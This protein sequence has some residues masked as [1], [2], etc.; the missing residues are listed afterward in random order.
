MKKCTGKWMEKGRKLGVMRQK[1]YI[2]S[3]LEN[4]QG[5]AFTPF[6]C[7]LPLNRV[8]PLGRFH[9]FDR[10]YDPSLFYL[11]ATIMPHLHPTSTTWTIGNM[12]S[13][14]GWSEGTTSGAETR[15]NLRALHTAKWQGT[16]HG[17]RVDRYGRFV[18]PTLP[19]VGRYKA[20]G[21]ARALRSSLYHPPLQGWDGCVK[22]RLVLGLLT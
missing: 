18:S 6:R 17:G 20:R 5:L 19:R 8:R 11:P 21:S 3:H 15:G 9:R 12:F 7:F 1:G 13:G 10:P 16:R 2:I 22:R 14:E 4:I